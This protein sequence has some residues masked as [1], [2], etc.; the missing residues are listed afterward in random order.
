MSADEAHSNDYAAGT[1]SEQSF[2]ERKVVEQSRETIAAYRFSKLGTNFAPRG[3]YA[4]PKPR[5]RPRPE[6]PGETRQEANARGGLATRRLLS[7]PKAD[8]QQPGPAPGFREPPAR[9]YNPYA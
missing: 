1:T 5:P 8:K 7:P 2:A 3:E 4:R 6:A 9:S